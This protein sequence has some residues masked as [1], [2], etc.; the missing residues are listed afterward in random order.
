MSVG[1]L[2]LEYSR[3]NIIFLTILEFSTFAAMVGA[4]IDIC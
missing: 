3:R 2:L 4:M 1:L